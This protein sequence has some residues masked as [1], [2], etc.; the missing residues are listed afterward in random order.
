MTVR[1]EIGR[2]SRAVRDAALALVVVAALALAGCGRD[3]SPTEPAPTPAA[4]AQ[5]LIV[6]GN[7]SYTAG[8]YRLAVKRYA[9][10]A[11]VDKEDPAAYFGLG[12]ALSKL[13]RDEEARQAYARSRELAQKRH[14]AST[15]MP[16]PAGAPVPPGHPPTGSGK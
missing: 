12:M 5:A 8:D 7:R 14:S 9:A 11:M 16:A 1:D 6:S 3:Q 10:A 4:R 15:P 13:G 2:R